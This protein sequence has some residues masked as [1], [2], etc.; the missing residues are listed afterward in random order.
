MLQPIPLP[1]NQLRIQSLPHCE[2]HE[3]RTGR[4]IRTLADACTLE[5]SRLGKNRVPTTVDVEVKNQW[6]PWC[7]RNW[8]RNALEAYNPTTRLSAQDLHIRT[9]VTSIITVTCSVNG[10]FTNM[11]TNSLGLYH[12]WSW[13]TW[14]RGCDHVPSPLGLPTGPSHGPWI[15]QSFRIEPVQSH[16]ADSPKYP[17]STDFSCIIS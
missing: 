13:Y 17:V 12:C 9:H 2:V 10:M 1:I 15:C 4:P 11:L 3:A 16:R 6:R 5:S 14:T 8:Y 7:T